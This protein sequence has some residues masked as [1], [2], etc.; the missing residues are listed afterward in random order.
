MSYYCTTCKKE[1]QPKSRGFKFF[2]LWPWSILIWKKRCPI[3]NLKVSYYCPTCKKEA[4]PKSRGFKFFILWP[5]S[6]L[7]WKKRC[8]IC[9]SKVS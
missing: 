5:W 4:Q 1:V 9:N 3:C 8:P 7:I 2:I 6:I